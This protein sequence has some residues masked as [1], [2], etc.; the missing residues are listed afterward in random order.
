MTDKNGNG[1]STDEP[2]VNDNDW[3]RPAPPNPN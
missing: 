2:T 3:G 1:T